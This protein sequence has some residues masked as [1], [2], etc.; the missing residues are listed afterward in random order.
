[1]DRSDV[2]TLVASIKSQN[3]YGVWEETKTLKEV[4]CQVEGRVL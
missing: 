1:M 4:F 2:I 3:A